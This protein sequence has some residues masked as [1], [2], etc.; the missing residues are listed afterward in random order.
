M[1]WARQT[2]RELADEQLELLTRLQTLDARVAYA[3]YGIGPLISCSWC[4]SPTGEDADGNYAT[5]FALHNLPSLALSYLAVLACMGV[6]SGG[7]RKRWRKPAVYLIGGAVVVEVWMRLSWQG[8]RGGA[9][10]VMVCL[11][12]CCCASQKLTAVL[13]L[14]SM[15][16]CTSF[17]MSFSRSSPSQ[18]TSFPPPTLLPPLP[19]SPSSSPLSTPSLS[20]PKLPSRVYERPTSSASPS[21]PASLLG[22]RC[23]PS[24]LHPGTSANTSRFLKTMVYWEN[25]EREGDIA[26]ADPAVQEARE[27]IASPWRTTL[28]EGKSMRQWLDEAMV[29]TPRQ[30]PQ[31]P[32]AAT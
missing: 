5:D 27:K 2:G 28:Q 25:H 22:T 32:N 12:L 15:L 30:P 7:A 1:R 17:D 3:G 31:E 20:K 8:A 9:Q 16:K 29:L 21:W 24:A 10:V 4:R 19:Q 26:R 23:A 6:L 18:C 14:S 13:P 11:G